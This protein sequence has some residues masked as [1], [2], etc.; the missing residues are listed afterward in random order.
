[1]P[2]KNLKYPFVNRTRNLPVSSTVPQSSAQSRARRDAKNHPG[3]SVITY[4]VWRY[5]L[6]EKSLHV[7]LHTWL[8]AGLSSQKAGFDLRSV[9]VGV[10]MDRVTFEQVFLRT[11]INLKK[12]DVSEQKQ[13]MFYRSDFHSS[14]ENGAHLQLYMQMTK[15]GVEFASNLINIPSNYVRRF[16]VHLK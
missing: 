12:R 16:G 14:Q 5:L 7:V 10:L 1:M 8:M 9:H 3:P 11:S 4:Q 2:I 6:P 15:I 13:Q